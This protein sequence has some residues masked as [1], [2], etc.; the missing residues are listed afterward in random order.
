MHEGQVWEGTPIPLSG[1]EVEQHR[2]N[3]NLGKVL[4]L[5][6]QVQLQLLLPPETPGGL[7]RVMTALSA[8]SFAA[9]AHLSDIAVA[10][11]SNMLHK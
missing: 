1:D 4:Y 9:L 10:Q 11:L 7:T 5:D 2:Y 6:G 3:P 8:V